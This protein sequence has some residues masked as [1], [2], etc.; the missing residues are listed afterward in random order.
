M[1]GA[2]DKEEAAMEHDAPG[3]KGWSGFPLFNKKCT[4]AFNRTLLLALIEALE[5]EKENGAS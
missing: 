5:V 1:T 4:T 2:R 3:G